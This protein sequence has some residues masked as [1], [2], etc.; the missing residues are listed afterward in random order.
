[1]A[2]TTLKLVES[3]KEIQRRIN[4]ALATEVNKAL[5]KTALKV[6]API[7]M[8][9]KAAL[10]NQPEV[11]SVSGGRLAAEFGLPDGRSRIDN[12]ITQWVDGIIVKVN[13][14]TTTSSRIN[15]GLTI[16]MIP[17]NFADVLGLASSR[18]TTDKGQDLPW[19]EWLLLFGDK[20]IVRD[21]S[22]SFDSDRVRRSRSGLAVMQSNRGAFWRVP[23][24]FAGTEDNN[25][26]TRAL[27][28]IQDD[29]I[30]IIETQMRSV[31]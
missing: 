12:I 31:I 6:V 15:A 17:R 25:F 19:L 27:E 26:V 28:T 30:G 16:Q 9:I 21:Y 14:A 1:M 23:P 18:V 4:K 2:K 20:A 11:A 13:K 24:E 5:D 29:I 8:A 3:N 22:I 10:L 7:K